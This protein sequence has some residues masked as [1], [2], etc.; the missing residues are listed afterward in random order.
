MPVWFRDHLKTFAILSAVVAIVAFMV[1]VFYAVSQ[2][3][4]WL[5]L[6]EGT[7]PTLA[8]VVLI[9]VG[10]YLMVR[11]SRTPEPPNP[12]IERRHRKGRILH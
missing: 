10:V 2:I 1:L 11:G 5:G 7:M 6:R 9:Y 3:P 8:F 12:F 4:Q